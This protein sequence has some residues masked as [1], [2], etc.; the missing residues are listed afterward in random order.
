M[1]FQRVR[2]P[3]RHCFEPGRQDLRCDF[4]TGTVAFA[5]ED[6]QARLSTLLCIANTDSFNHHLP[7]SGRRDPAESRDDA[8]RDLV[9]RAC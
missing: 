6:R 3:R 8:I 9:V 7:Y 2:G 5:P 1:H 4:R